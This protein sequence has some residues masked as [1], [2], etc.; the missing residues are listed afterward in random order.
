MNASVWHGAP[1]HTSTIAPSGFRNSD[2]CSRAATVERGSL[3][4]SSPNCG[5]SGAVL[6]SAPL[7]L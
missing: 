7:G 2:F 4:G 1:L 6:V 3:C 5:S